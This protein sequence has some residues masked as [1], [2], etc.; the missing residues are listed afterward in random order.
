M[1]FGGGRVRSSEWLGHLYRGPD[2]A[3]AQL[4]REARST[5]RIFCR[6]WRAQMR[7]PLLGSLI[8]GVAAA[9]LLLNNEATPHP[10]TCMIAVGANVEVASG[11][12]WRKCDGLLFTGRKPFGL[13]SPQRIY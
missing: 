4:K 11:C 8:D 1:G 9:A 2:G 12:V 10:E 6:S 5:R 13:S 7:P 3:A